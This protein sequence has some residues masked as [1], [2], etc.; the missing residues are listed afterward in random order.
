[1][2]SKPRVP[3][4]NQAFIKAVKVYRANK[5]RKEERAERRAADL[6]LSLALPPATLSARRLPDEPTRA[7]ALVGGVTVSPV[8]NRKRSATKP[9]AK[10]LAAEKMRDHDPSTQRRANIP[11]TCKERPD[12]NKPKTGGRGPGKPR[13]DFIPWCK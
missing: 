4:K 8:E 12:N 13:V 9:L 11:P 1:M 3:Y 6:P 2:A 10:A 7:T 5:L